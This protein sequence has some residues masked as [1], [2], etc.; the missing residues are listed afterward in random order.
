[1]ELI[2]ENLE[3]QPSQLILSYA[4]PHKPVTSSTIARYIKLFIEMAGIDVTVFSAHSTRSTSTSKANNLGL[5]MRYITK[6][7]GWSS[8]ES[9]IIFQFTKTLVEYYLKTVNSLFKN[10]KEIFYSSV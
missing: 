1:M 9:F 10:F 4:Y 5:S 7:G 8:S 3:G 6:A 2:R